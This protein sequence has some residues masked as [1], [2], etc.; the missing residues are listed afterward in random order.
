MAMLGVVATLGPASEEL[1]TIAALATVV[2]RFRLNTSHLDPPALER[3]FERLAQLDESLHRPV[4]LDLQGAKM[5][6]GEPASPSA[7]SSG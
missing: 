3:W 6:V 5:R 4:V 2:D 7:S 1:S